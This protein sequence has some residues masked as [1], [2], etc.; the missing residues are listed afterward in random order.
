M[1]KLF[2][3]KSL[4]QLNLW[5][6]MYDLSLSLGQVGAEAADPL[7]QYLSL[8]PFILSDHSEEVWEVISKVKSHTDI[9]GENIEILAIF[10]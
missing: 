5:G 7:D 4:F 3:N 1:A 9:V 8:E 2:S 10:F 6:N